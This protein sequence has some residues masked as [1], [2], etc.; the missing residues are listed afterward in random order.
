LAS[1][2]PR[3]GPSGVLVVPRERRIRGA[4]E[5]RK[6]APPA[7]GNVDSAA[8]ASSCCI[9]H[10]ESKPGRPPGKPRMKGRKKKK[11][12]PLC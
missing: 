11:R 7:P 12:P 3:P 1:E 4:V 6:G 10:Q 5:A 8:S 9:L 2:R